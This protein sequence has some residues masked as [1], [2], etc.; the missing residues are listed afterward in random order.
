MEFE[1]DSDRIG[2]SRKLSPPPSS[3]NQD[4]DNNHQYQ[5]Q[6]SSNFCL[7][8]DSATSSPV[9]GSSRRRLAGYLATKLSNLT[10]LASGGGSQLQ[11]SGGASSSS[12][13]TSPLTKRS[14]MNQ[15]QQHGGATKDRRLNSGS[16]S[17]LVKN[18]A[19][20]QQHYYYYFGQSPFYPAK[21]YGG[22]D[23]ILLIEA[24]SNLSGSNASQTN[25]NTNS[26]SGGGGS[27]AGSGNSGHPI[28]V[29]LVA[30][31]LQEKAAWM[32]DISQVSL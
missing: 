32:S 25:T 5:L 27:G 10:N 30:P 26:L 14:G 21:D 15:L 28:A 1:L 2:N 16:V 3:K 24:T 23:F 17:G 29:H 11:V 31:N 13:P 7:T 12:A 9:K 22:C 19:S 20:N 6:S 4:F 18:T 8:D